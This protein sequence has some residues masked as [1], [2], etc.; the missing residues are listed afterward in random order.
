MNGLPSYQRKQIHPGIGE[1]KI[2][3]INER[4]T[5]LMNQHTNK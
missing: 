1:Q 3:R 2:Y 5:E 4:C